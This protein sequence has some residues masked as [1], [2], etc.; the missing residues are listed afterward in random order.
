MFI[1]RPN[2][3]SVITYESLSALSTLVGNNMRSEGSLLYSSKAWVLAL[4][5]FKLNDSSVYDPSS[6]V[7]VL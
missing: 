6:E 3:K 5:D 2:T 1:G 4:I 7:T